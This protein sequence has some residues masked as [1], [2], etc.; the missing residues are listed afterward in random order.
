MKTLNWRS[1]WT[2]IHAKVKRSSLKPWEWLNKQFKTI[3]RSWVWCRNNEITFHMKGLLHRIAQKIVEKAWQCIN[4]NGQ[5]F[6]QSGI[7]KL[8]ERWERVVANNGQYFEKYIFLTF[9]SQNKAS[10]L[11]TKKSIKTYLY[12]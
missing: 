4:L 1:Y 2:K 12:T 3:P 5:E 7:C 10:T 9:I 6:F 11:Q 8:P